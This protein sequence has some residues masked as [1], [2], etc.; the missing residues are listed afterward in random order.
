MDSLFRLE[1]SEL[2]GV[3][4]SGGGDAPAVV[5]AASDVVSLVESG[6]VPPVA[7]LEAVD[8][9]DAGAP[10]GL[11]S[12]VLG[13]LQT[14]LTDPALTESPLVVVTRG[15]VAAGESGVLDAAG[16]AVWG[17]VRAAQ[18][19]Y[20]DRV[21]LLDVEP[22]A[23]IG[24]GLLAGV[25]AAG[26]PQVA[27]RGAVVSVPRLARAASVTGA[28]EGGFDPEGAV[29]ITGGTGSLAGVLARHLVSAHGVRHLVL[30]SRRGPAAEG[31]AELVEE[32]SAEGATATVVACDVSD[33]DAVAG[34][35]DGISAERR[36][37]GVIHTAGVLDDCLLGALNEERLAGV[38]APKAAAA[39]HL[40]ELTRG[41]DLDAF[42]VFSSAAGIFG[43]AGQGNY[44]AANAYLDALMLRRRA[45]GLPG[46]SLAWGLWA[47]TSG[48]MTG[49]LGAADQARMGRGGVLALSS[50]EG[51]DLF[52][53]A[54]AGEQALLV[55]MKLDLRA[56]RAEAT[57]GG[58]VQPVLRGLVRLGRRTVQAGAGDRN[59]LA[60]RLAGLAPADQEKTLL[61]LVRTHTATVLGHATVERVDADKAFKDAGFDSLTAVELRNRL[62]TATGVKLPATLIFDYP[63]PRA[64]ARHLR[65]EF[66][67][68][69][70]AVAPL[71]PAASVSTDDDPI[72]IVGMACRLP[73]GVTG[74]ESLWRMVSEGREGLSGFPTDRGWDLEGL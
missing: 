7:V 63:T 42:V 31:A 20:P 58:G 25:L 68:R 71:A 67:G 11:L 17:L 74:P 18:A 61:D 2:S 36:L 13:V 56:V 53:S 22:G 50:A 40:D 10:V 57:A 59:A 70:S 27:V 4:V 44:A 38:F 64:L 8:T 49:H 43:S 12:R 47:Q 30:A 39:H 26:E 54:V 29:L 69:T 32:L 48:G 73:G 51:M 1:W 23:E 65:D 37:S 35:L 52:D 5:T 60:Q 9:V 66:G 41:L 6:V 55:P 14:W 3:T 28:G 62:S 33:R 46:V 16:A 21:V 72:V 19:E 15:A 34:L 45:A 24:S